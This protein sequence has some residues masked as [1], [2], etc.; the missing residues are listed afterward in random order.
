MRKNLFVRA[1]SAALALMLGCTACFAGAIGE[2]T[3]MADHFV[4]ENPD[5][6]PADG[7]ELI[8]D[9]ASR[10]S[11]FGQD[12]GTET[13]DGVRYAGGV[14][15]K[16]M[17]PMTFG[18]EK[19][20]CV[21]VTITGRFDSTEDASIRLYLANGEMANCSDNVVTIA[22]PGK[23]VFTQRVDLAAAMPADRVMLA[24][25]SF[26]DYF[27]DFTLIS[28]VV[29]SA[30]TDV[31]QLQSSVSYEEAVQQAWYQDLLRKAQLN[32][33]NNKRI[34]RVIER[35]QA[36]EHITLATIG[37]SITEGAGATRYKEC[38]A[39]QIFDG[40]RRAYG[41]GDGSNVSFVNAGVGGTPST[42]GWMRY[43]REVVDRVQ[44]DDNLPDLVVVEYAVNDGGEPTRHQCYESMVKSILEQPNEPA[45]ILLFS[46][47]PTGYTLQ[48]ELTPVG[49]T[50]DL[51][52]VSMADS[53]FPYV[54]NKW[55]REAFFYDEYHP[56]TMG[57]KVMADCVLNAIAAA[58]A[59]PENEA[60]VDLSVKP[61]YG[62][63]YMGMQCIFR[64][65]I[66]ERL[67]M[68]LGGFK[69]DDQGAYK[70]QPVGRVCGRNFYHSTA[71][72]EEPMTF[73]AT[74]KNLLIAY[75][76]VTDA[77]FGT[78][79]VLID[80]EPVAKLKAN[81]GSWGQS[82]V[83][84]VYNSKDAAEHEVVIRMSQGDEKKKFTITCIS[85]T[86]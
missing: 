31:K 43:Q 38:Y 67:N 25:S 26:A 18:I 13:E 36:G 39:Y 75:R 8:I 41:A 47:F 55:T 11:V 64:D 77:K 3:N 81:T 32:L 70:N 76:T 61:A 52:M 46:V 74:F 1:A 56:T 86:P 66:D 80:G 85:Y 15:N 22:N 42:F 58:A 28:L 20:Q 51:M 59:L 53:A 17:F 24:S 10:E 45:V 82:V 69:E 62:L 2:A 19:N 30:V 34:K 63:S 33:G 57:H 35:A 37:G 48:K 71:G 9:L 12:I 21:S 60:D 79:E 72:G 54:G 78:A 4:P 49:R 16:C 50:Y 73:T 6:M 23:E 29:D 5:Q 68:Q 40:F 83:D 27:Q 7:E 14:I 44:D 65:S 84:L